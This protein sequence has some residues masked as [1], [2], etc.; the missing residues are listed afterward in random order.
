MNP[1][2]V[3]VYANTGNVTADLGGATQEGTALPPTPTIVSGVRPP[4]Q[5]MEKILREV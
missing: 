5:K 1:Q 4:K 2:K 3:S